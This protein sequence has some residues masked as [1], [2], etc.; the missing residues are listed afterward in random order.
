[1]KHSLTHI[2]NLNISDLNL[3]EKV[4][5]LLAHCKHKIDTFMYLYV[6]MSCNMCINTYMYAKKVM[7]N[8]MA[9]VKH[10]E[11]SRAHSQSMHIK[12]SE[13]IAIATLVLQFPHFLNLL[14]IFM[15]VFVF[16]WKLKK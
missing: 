1:M 16:A 13:K 7:P 5:A 2:A 10:C 14:I 3:V 8:S 11:Y 12:A 4:K 15:Y 6:F 9:S